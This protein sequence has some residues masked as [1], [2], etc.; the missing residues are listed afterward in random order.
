M[1]NIIVIYL[2]IFTVEPKEIIIGIVLGAKMILTVDDNGIR[3]EPDKQ[4]PILDTLLSQVTPDNQHKEVDF[5]YPE[6]D[7]LI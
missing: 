5:G 2:R 7:E 6:G 4:K 1:A 3:L